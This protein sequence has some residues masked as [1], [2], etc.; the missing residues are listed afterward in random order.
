MELYL[1]KALDS[2]AINNAIL[3]LIP[4]WETLLRFSCCNLPKS[5]V[6]TLREIVWNS[7]KLVFLKFHFCIN[8]KFKF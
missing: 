8:Q 7:S 6:L 3:K 2:H 4:R 1:K 5:A